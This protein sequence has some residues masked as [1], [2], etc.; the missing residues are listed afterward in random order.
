MKQK[1]FQNWSVMRIFLS[2]FGP[3]KKLFILDMCCAF[4]VAV[5][6]LSDMD[7]SEGTSSAIAN[8]SAPGKGLVWCSGTYRVQFS[9]Q[10]T[11]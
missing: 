10:E 8:L 11:D 5:V 3:H 1:D 7:L 4:L 6:D 9:V 2:Y